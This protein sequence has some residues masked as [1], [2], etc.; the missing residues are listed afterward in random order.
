VDLCYQALLRRYYSSSL[1]RRV[2]LNKEDFLSYLNRSRSVS[3]IAPTSLAINGSFC[4]VS[5]NRVLHVSE[6]GCLERPQQIFYKC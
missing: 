1:L 2:R 6:E 3:E 4:V 5:A